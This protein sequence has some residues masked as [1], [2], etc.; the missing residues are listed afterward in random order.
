MAANLNLNRDLGRRQIVARD[1]NLPF[2]VG[3]YMYLPGMQY[4]QP[5]PGTTLLV[6][7]HSIAQ[8][9]GFHGG[10]DSLLL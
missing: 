3:S 6:R 9:I 4:Q 10:F 8:A 1:N 2:Q 7:G 5:Y